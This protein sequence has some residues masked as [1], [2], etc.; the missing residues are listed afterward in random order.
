L[1]NDLDSFDNSEPDC[2]SPPTPFERYDHFNQI[3]KIQDNS[4][5]ICRDSFD[6]QNYADDECSPD[7]SSGENEA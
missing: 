4:F 1:N 6:I 5:A 7:V 2:S 3:Q